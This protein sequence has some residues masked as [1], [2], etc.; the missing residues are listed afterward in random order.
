MTTKNT[1]RNIL[2]ATACMSLPLSACVNDQDSDEIGQALN[3]VNGGLDMEDEAPEFGDE[4]QF[5]PSEE[6]DVTDALEEDPDVAAME[7]NPD[8]VRYH[9]A[10]LWGQFPLNFEAEADRDWS[11]TFSLN[12]GALLVRRTIAFE[13]NDSIT[14]RD[15]RLSVSFT[16]I[17]RPARDGFR[18]SIIDPTPESEEPLMLT[19]SDASGEVYSVAMNS[20]AGAPHSYDAGDG[21]K[22]VTMTI[23]RPL[24][25]CNFGYIGGHWQQVDEDRG[26]LHGQVRGADGEL[27]GHMRGIYG[28]RA[29]GKRVFFGKYIGAEGQFRGLFAGRYQDEKFLGRWINKSG[30]IGAL[31]G[32]FRE[33]DEG[34]FVGRWAETSC[35]VEVGPGED[36]PTDL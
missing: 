32:Q 5:D 2:F 20:L 11:G 13:A 25:V 4:G 33:G 31:G 29:N 14:P 17:T 34:H 1:L 21:N 15:N 6:A 10:I 22:I 9:T 30:D 28:E 12:R 8:A 26:R 3:E 36:L 7:A 19:Y 35:N 27:K 16:S 23:K 18:L 24:N